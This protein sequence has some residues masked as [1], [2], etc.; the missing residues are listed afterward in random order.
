M[1]SKNQ[2]NQV[3]IKDQLRVA[4]RAQIQ[5]ELNESLDKVEQFQDAQTLLKNEISALTAQIDDLRALRNAKSVELNQVNTFLSRFAP[6][7][8]DAMI[9]QR[10]DAMLAVMAGQAIKPAR[11]TKTRSTSVAKIDGY[12]VSYA[13]DGQ[14]RSYKTKTHLTYWLGQKLGQKVTVDVLNSTFQE[15]TSIVP[16]S[17]EH[18]DQGTITASFDGIQVSI[19]LTPAQ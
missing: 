12:N 11:S 8:I 18:K 1:T 17:Q 5:A 13:I 2:T 19:T 4:I 3:D 15:Q 16:F 6:D 7:A 9:D 14:P 10:L